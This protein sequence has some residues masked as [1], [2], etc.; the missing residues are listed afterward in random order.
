MNIIC[1][2][3]TVHGA[4]Y[5]S[6]MQ[7]FVLVSDVSYTIELITFTLLYSSVYLL[8]TKIPSV[9]VL[10]Y[11][12]FMSPASSA[13]CFDSITCQWKFKLAMDGGVPDEV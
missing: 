3:A 1:L 4:C 5:A 6:L 8:M 11:I 12:M 10:L 2:C 9:S 13:A 7:A